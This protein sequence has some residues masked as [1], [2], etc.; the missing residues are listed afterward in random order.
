MAGELHWNHAI[1]DIAQKGLTHERVATGE[2]RERIARALDLVACTKL[3]TRYTILPSSAGCYVLSG[4]LEAEVQQPCVVT[5]E[6][7]VSSIAETFDFAFWP[8]DAM[9]APPSGEL[10]LN[11]EQETAPIVD[12]DIEVGR[13]VMALLAETI[14]PFPRAPGAALERQTAT[15]K[16]TPKDEPASPF[17]VLARIRTRG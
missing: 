7:V 14:D 2:E 1:L 16:G 9:P 4:S 3:M 6:P 10:D 8:N 15:P 11:E 12:G 13:V 5:L 17:A